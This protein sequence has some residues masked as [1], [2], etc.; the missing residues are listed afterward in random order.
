MPSSTSPP[1]PLLRCPSPSRPRCSSVPPGQCATTPPTPRGATAVR[2]RILQRGLVGDLLPPRR[3]GQLLPHKEDHR[4]SESTTA[5][6]V[7]HTTRRTPVAV[8]R[9]GQITH[10]LWVCDDPAEL[11]RPASG[12]SVG[13]ALIANGHHRHAA[14]LQLS[15][16]AAGPWT[17]SL[18]LLVDAVT[19]ASALRDPPTAVRPETAESRGR[20]VRISCSGRLRG[21]HRIRRTRAAR[22][23]C[24]G[25]AGRTARPVNDEVAR[26]PFER[27]P[28]PAR[29][30]VARRGA[31][32]SGRR[33]GID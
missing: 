20:D 17:G 15:G 1:C 26:R 9:T 28:L 33:P 3:A 8:A 19:S 23:D 25:R 32:G 21:R 31:I 13:Q 14:C 7:E 22:L 2:G 16:D 4:G 24:P 27:T 5:Q 29:A 10:T 18:A 11:A 12:L 6:L 30:G